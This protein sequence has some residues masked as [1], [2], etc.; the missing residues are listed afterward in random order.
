M[1]KTKTNYWVYL[2]IAFAFVVSAVSGIVF[3]LPIS[4][5]TILG[6][7]YTVWDQVHT[8]GSL[9]MITGVLAHL[10]LHWKWIVAMTRKTFFA[11]AKPARTVTAATTGASSLSRR[12]FLRTAGLGA[13]ALGTAAV[14]YKTIFGSQ[15]ADAAE[16]AAASIPLTVVPTQANSSAAPAATSVPTTAQTF[17]VACPKGLTVRPL[18]WAMSPLC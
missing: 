12:Q 3:L 6:V 14:G 17:T 2:I 9:L 16:A 1:N 15:T 8:L 10:V 4:G 7:S 5:S 13:V 18:S 11:P